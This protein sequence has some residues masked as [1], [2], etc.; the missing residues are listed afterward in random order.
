MHLPPVPN[1][2]DSNTYPRNLRH[3]GAA[4]F[5][6]PLYHY[7]NMGD[8]LLCQI[9]SVY[10]APCLKSMKLSSWHQPVES[11]PVH[12]P[13]AATKQ[14]HKSHAGQLFQ[15][16]IR[17]LTLAEE[18]SCRSVAFPAISTGVYRFPKK[19]AAETAAGQ[20]AMADAE[21]PVQSDKQKSKRKFFGRKE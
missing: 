7:Q 10:I 17:S 9:P 19:E 2:R 3:R 13:H 15:C 21:T 20:V 6:T 18:N 5:Y 14:L 1:S 16:Y 8:S 4:L 11:L 12:H